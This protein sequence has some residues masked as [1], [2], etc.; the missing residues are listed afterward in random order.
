[1]RN[2]N[3]SN[4]HSINTLINLP[5]IESGLLDN[6]FVGTPED[7]NKFAE[8]KLGMPILIPADEKLFDFQL[9]EVFEIEKYR[10]PSIVYNH[11]DENY[12][13]FKHSF[14]KFKFLS[15]SLF[16]NFKIKAFKETLIL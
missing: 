10:L 7:L 6:N 1:M 14:R 13:G 2:R 11:Q 3:F 16:K 15:N 5:N 12:V 4:N 8:I 9:K